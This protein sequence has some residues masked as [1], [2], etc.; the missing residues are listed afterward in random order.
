VACASHFENEPFGVHLD[1]AVQ[2][3]GAR[4]DGPELTLGA[5]R[6]IGSSVVRRDAGGVQR[7]GAILAGLAVT[8]AGYVVGRWQ[9]RRP[10][11]EAG[12][13]S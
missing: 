2:L 11:A 8:T 7:A 12:E 6:Q 1:L 13:T 5:L 4:L 3:S 9:S 10:P